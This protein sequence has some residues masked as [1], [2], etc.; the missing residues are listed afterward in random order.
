MFSKFFINRPI[1]ATV[2]ALL[3]V[4]AGL[5]TL[6]ILPIAQYPEITPP[7]VQVSAVY[8]GA[9]AQTVAQTVGI[10]IE[11]Q[12]NG[13]DGM[14]YMSSNSS[15]SGAYSLTITFAVGTDIDMA[16][17]QVQNRVSVAQASLPTPV[18]VQGVTVQKQSSNIVM[19]LTM[20]SDNKEYDG[21]Y[22]SNYATLNLADQLTR[23]PGVGAVNVMGAGDY[24]MRIWLDPAALR[25]RNLS[26]SDVYQA[27]QA[28]NVEVSAGTVGQ[29]LPATE[30][31][32]NSG[33][34]AYQYT[35]TVKGRLSSPE[36]F[37]NIILRTE[38]GGRV[39]RLRDVAHIDL[40]SASYNVVSRL[41]GQPTAAIAI[42]Q[43]PGS[44]SL[45]VSKGVRA[46][47]QELSQSF[48]QGIDYSV[49]L[50]TTDVIHASVDE[51]LVT[52]LETTLLVVLVIFLFL[53]NWRAVIIPCITIPVSLIG[54]LAVMALF[55]FS[56][57]TLTLFGL[58][59]AVAIVVDDAIVVV[60]NSSRLLDTG[61]YSAREAVIKAMGEITGPIV[62]V[63]LVLLAVFIPTMLISGIS[64]QLYKQFALTIAA[65]TVLSGINSLTLTPALCA[66]IL[67]PTKPAKSPLFRGFNFVYD[68]TQGVYDRTVGWLLR[69]PGAALLSY[70]VFTALAVIL[71]IKWPSTFIPEEDDGYFLAV[72]QLPPASSLERTETVGR[73]INEILNSYPEVKNYIGISGFSVMGGGE[74]SNSG[75]YFVILKN[76]DERKG[77]EHTAQAIVNR[78][79]A[80]AYG[81]QEAEVFAMV[82]PAIPGLGATGGLQLQ[83]EDRKNL[84]ATEMQR[85]VE[86]LME[87]YHTKSA[88]AS[89]S[90]QY[91]ANVPQYFLNVDRDK[92]QLM[93]IPLNSVFTTLGYYMGAAY[94]NDFVEFGRIYQ[95]KLGAR[96]HA[97]RVIDD[98]LKL[99][100]PNA[101]G[102][103]VP[104]S[105]FTKVEEQLGMD[106]INRYNMYSTASITCN[107]MPGS[108]SGEAIQQ[109]EE[110]FR[111][112]LGDE[113]GYEWTS[114]AYQE[115]QA[116]TTTSTVL[117][118]A[119]LVA[120]L[121]LAAQYESWTS[122]VSAVMGLPVAL[123][124]A[125]IGCLVMGTPV[126][127][128]TQIGIILLVA[129]SAKNGILIVEFARD[130]R[131][132]GN[133]IRDAAFQAGHIRLRP[134]LM[135]SL[136]FVL[137]VMPLLFASGA[138]AESR[139]ALGAAVV[140]GMALN[141][142]LATVYIPNFYELMQKL[143]E[144][145]SRKKE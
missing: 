96:D 124:G 95:V 99:S 54:T 21:L 111:E 72:V 79:N 109:M 24:S 122:P 88:L 121:V 30:T 41:N 33:S 5:V 62:G 47:M 105:A 50:D 8:P 126:S 118:M 83:L 23:V 28:Q 91:Q 53:Q 32:G 34:P 92:V 85:A 31:S 127:I 7:T 2:L 65:S 16:T 125:M 4:V 129:L 116:G 82:P 58:I 74:Q 97:Q 68:K 13:V 119:L 132:E 123:L 93:G 46:K 14:L 138:G 15:S 90:S 141:T 11:Q 64:G 94:V 63:V 73:E 52:F 9:N 42:Y 25:I 22:L 56:I 69:R 133:S 120:F 18:V 48:P 115:T 143:Q 37:G 87:T 59:L 6:G 84:G 60:E 106:Q 110:L 55:G 78:F 104:F 61:Q 80:Q 137:G 140:F 136:A 130:F 103:M 75:T 51:V 17:V 77:K 86:A 100:V 145:F 27:I 26:A 36:E 128:Y 76:W 70:A 139:I 135:T 108:S 107:V 45:D 49:T 102:E 19:F 43:Q 71:F 20:T 89:V 40:G 3:I 112:Q 117:L 57:N 39:L 67:Q 131:A 29:P 12:V 113:F 81:I 38:T 98:V 142:L 144:R 35:L 66:L 134:I 44:N 1:F 10:P 101:A 114:V